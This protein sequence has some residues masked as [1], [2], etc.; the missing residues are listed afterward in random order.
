MGGGGWWGIGFKSLTLPTLV[1]DVRCTGG[2]GGGLVVMRWG[3][4][5]FY[6]F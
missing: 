4:I 5:Y 1:M 2:G 6:F 3:F